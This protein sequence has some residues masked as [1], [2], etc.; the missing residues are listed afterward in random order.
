[1]FVFF[2]VLIIVF[3]VVICFDLSICM[4]RLFM[5]LFKYVSSYCFNI[6]LC[7]LYSTLLFL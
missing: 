4:Y 2:V 1:M 6:V 3:V 7:L 5:F